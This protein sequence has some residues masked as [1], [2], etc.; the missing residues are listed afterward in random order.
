MGAI[1]TARKFPNTRLREIYLPPFHAAVNAG[2][3]T[4]MSAFNSLNG[5]PAS[6]NPFTLTQILR[7]EWGFRGIVDSDWTS[8]AEVM[9]HGIAN[10]GATAA[11]KAFL[12][13]VDMDMA[14]SLYHDHLAETGAS[15]VRCRWR[16]SMKAFAACCASS[17]RSGLFDH[18]YVDEAKENAAM[19]QP[20]AITLARTAA[21]RSFVL[22]KNEAAGWCTRASAFG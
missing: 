19:L 20:E 6:A 13:G 11:R 14:S 17:L 7:K 22:L 15:P 4:I 21:E 8:I 16:T 2:S 18:P 5:V 1:T 3:G 9:A 10:D 12:A